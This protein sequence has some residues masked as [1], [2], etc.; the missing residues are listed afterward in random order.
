MTE[1]YWAGSGHAQDRE[2][3]REEY[4][5]YLRWCDT[6]EHDPHDPASIDAWND[7]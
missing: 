5:A 4:R 3:L 6:N 7:R 2:E 1:A